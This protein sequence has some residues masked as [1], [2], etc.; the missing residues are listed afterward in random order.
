[1]AEVTRVRGVVNRWIDRKG[2]GFIDDEDGNTVFV[3]ESSI[4]MDGWRFLTAG[5]E[6]T[7]VKIEKEGGYHALN[8]MK[9]SKDEKTDE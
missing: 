8:V 3:H 9:V 5:D 4:R 1:M 7:F 2:Y 6:V